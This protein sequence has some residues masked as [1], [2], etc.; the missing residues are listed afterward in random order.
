MAE[1]T[2]ARI[3][4]RPLKGGRTVLFS[5]AGDKVEAVHVDRSGP[6]L[7]HWWMVVD[8]RGRSID[9]VKYPKLATVQPM[10]TKSGV[11]L[12]AAPSMPR[13]SMPGLDHH[14]G[15]VIKVLMGKEQCD[16]IDQGDAVAKWMSKLL[17]RPS[18]VARIPLGGR[19]RESTSLGRWFAVNYTWWPFHIITAESLEAINACLAKPIPADRFR[20]TLVI[21][22]A[23]KAYDEDDW[24]L[25]KIGDLILE[26]GKKCE[27]CGVIQ[28]DEETSS[29]EGSEGELLAALGRHRR[30]GD[31]VFFGVNFVHLDTGIIGVG[32]AVKVLERAAEK[33]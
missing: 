21:V 30:E 28:I 32:D 13:V 1:M 11:L 2:V 33:S 14:H 17:G 3:D 31:K 24:R 10:M 9:Q 8:E 19:R 29:N 22:G 18:R 25:I 7:D 5:T 26:F 6:F 27:R 12:L 20:A 23:Q 4:I 16:G 15:T